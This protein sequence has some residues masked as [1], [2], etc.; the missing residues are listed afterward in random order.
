MSTSQS[1]AGASE[2]KGDSSGGLTLPPLDKEPSLENSPDPE[3]EALFDESVASSD[4]DDGTEENGKR[5]RSRQTANL[6]SPHVLE[7]GRLVPQDTTNTAG[8]DGVKRQR[9]SKSPTGRSHA[10]E[11]IVI[12]DDV[13]SMSSDPE[14]EVPKRNHRRSGGGKAGASGGKDKEVGGGTQAS[15]PPDS[16]G[17]VNNSRNSNTAT[18][19]SNVKG[20][21]GAHK[22]NSGKGGNGATKDNTGNDGN[23]KGNPPEDPNAP[24][25]GPKPDPSRMYTDYEIRM[26]DGW[27]LNDGTFDPQPMT[28]RRKIDVPFPQ[29]VN[30]TFRAMSGLS[31]LQIAH[32]T[33]TGTPALDVAT[34]H[35]WKCLHGDVRRKVW[36]A[37]PNG[38]ALWSGDEDAAKAMY[39]KNEQDVYKN[40][41]TGE[42]I[43]YSQIKSCPWVVWPLWVED[44]FGKDFVTVL[45]YSQPRDSAAAAK[46]PPVYDQLVRYTVI[47]PRRAG[48]A[49]QIPGAPANDP[50]KYDF[51]HARTAR[52][53]VALRRF[54]THAGYDLSLVPVRSR[55]DGSRVS[56]L[57]V[58]HCSPMPTG[59]V[60][61]G[62]RCFA[63]VKELLERITQWHLRDGEHPEGVFAHLRPWINP[64]QFRIE[65]TGICAWMLMATLDYEARI[66]V[67]VIP[68]TDI[69]IMSDGT[70]KLIAP[71]DL[72][73]PFEFPPFAPKDWLLPAA[74][75][76]GGGGGGGSGGKA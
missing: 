10:Y 21:K 41:T 20:D 73:G 56:P 63:T 7:N 3:V 34:E 14:A 15:T 26:V 40:K 31:T 67:E 61:S 33:T 62:E 54:L 8:A 12:S 50:A 48:T 19:D 69:E 25:A 6:D 45:L 9:Q 30:H 49:T 23:G 29:L 76:A 46:D 52:L 55:N 13:S 71:Y 35:L 53:D 37:P 43:F 74:S 70:R 1:P 44:D 32:D 16:S 65:M 47:D 11:A 51:P 39:A 17:V 66:A 75:A 36:V 38:P 68:P 72:A 18:K 2:Q 4:V 60:S 5:K 28:K 59:E 42:Y 22:D 57:T 24:P 27:T 58:T 64:Y